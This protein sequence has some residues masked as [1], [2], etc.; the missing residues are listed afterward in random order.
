MA[1]SSDSRPAL[2]YD[3]EVLQRELKEYYISASQEDIDSMLQ[4]IG[5]G[6]LEDLF[7]HISSEVKFSKPLDLPDPL[8]YEALQDT[9]YN[10][11]CENT[12]H[13]SFLGDGLPQ[14]NVPEIVP[15]VCNIRNLTTSYTP[16]QPE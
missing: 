8:S 6:T 12:L 13:T 3:P 5:I 10:W 7:A 2:N 9:L 4:T 11:S 14:F 15:Y 1:P 16:Y